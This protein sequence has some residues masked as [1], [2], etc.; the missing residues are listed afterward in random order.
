MT[1][2][3]NLSTVPES[4]PAAGG[5][6][7]AAHYLPPHTLMKRLIR[8]SRTPGGEETVTMSAKTFNKLV[9]AA[10]AMIFDEAAY[11]DRYVDIRDAVRAGRLHSGLDHFVSDGYLEGRP[12]LRYAVDEEWYIQTYPDVAEAIKSGKVRDAAH[13]FEAFGF[14]EARVPN[15][16]YQRTIAEWRELEKKRLA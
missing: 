12:A 3:A 6:D 14:A 9:E 16:S 4:K 1:Q 13:H 5:T 15:K 7:K 10:A 2:T 11:L 8:R